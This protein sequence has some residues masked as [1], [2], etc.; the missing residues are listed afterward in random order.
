MSILRV[1]VNYCEFLFFV[2]ILFRLLGVSNLVRP[3][4]I[5]VKFLERISFNIIT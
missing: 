2:E 5:F 3:F 4:Q 1:L